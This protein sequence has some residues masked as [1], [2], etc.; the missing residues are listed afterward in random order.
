ML[1]KPR[2]Q[3]SVKGM[4]CGCCRQDTKIKTKR[5]TRRV[6]KRQWKKEMNVA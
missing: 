6:E 2:T 4:G 1:N 3:G 5:R